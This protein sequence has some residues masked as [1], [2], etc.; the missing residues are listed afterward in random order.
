MQ[1]QALIQSS[2]TRQVKQHLNIFTLQDRCNK[3]P[4]ILTLLLLRKLSEL[5]D[6]IYR[7][8][9]ALLD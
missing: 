1:F 5:S 7:T 9:L 4:L 6:A 2:L 3:T 8:E